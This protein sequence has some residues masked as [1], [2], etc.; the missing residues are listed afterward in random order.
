MV[1]IK[2]WQ[3]KRH[4]PIAVLFGI[5]SIE[6]FYKL[7]NSPLYFDEAI[8]AQVSKGILRRG[9]WV[10]LHWNGVAW[11]EKPP[12]FIWAT[13]IAFKIFWVGEFWARSISGLCGLGVVVVSYAAG[14]NLYNR[15]A[16]LVAGIILL[17]SPLF[18]FFSRSGSTDICLTFFLTLGLYFYLRSPKDSRYW[19]LVG[20]A[21]ACAA[22]VKGAAA[23]VGPLSVLAA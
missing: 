21:F 12:L 4:L 14:K 13:A 19:L 2:G 9:D 20:L 6:L 23:I 1:P 16:G 8:Y 17:A 10:T 3:L 15:T 5:A 18:V 7:G 11:F 22:L